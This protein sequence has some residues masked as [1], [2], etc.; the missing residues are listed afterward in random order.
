MFIYKGKTIK[1]IGLFGYGKSNKGIYEFFNT[2][3]ED[4]RFILRSDHQKDTEGAKFEKVLFGDV[5]L[6]RINEDILFL[7]PSV[8]RDKKELAFA[9]KRGVILSSDADFFLSLTKS[10]VYA[11]TGSDGKSTTTKLSAAMLSESYARAVACGNIGEAMTPH[12]SDGDNCAYVT[13]LSSFQLTYMKPKSQRALITNITKNHLNWHSSFDEYINAKRNVFEN[14]RERII[15][16]DCEI[17]RSFAKDYRIFS[18]FS[19]RL[20]EVELKKAV[21]AELYV[22]LNDGYITVSGEKML[23][24]SDIRVKG[25]HNVENFMAAI[26]MSYGLADKQLILNTAKEFTGLRHRCEFVGERDGIKY[27]D[28][29]IDSSPKRTSATLKTFDERVIVILGGRSKGLEFSDLIP[30]LKQKAKAVVLMGECAEEIANTLSRDP[31]FTT[32]IP[33]TIRACL[34]DALEYAASIARHGDSVL[35]S[36]AATSYDEFKN[37]EERGDAFCN[38]IH[39]L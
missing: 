33:Y 22:T 2:L 3:P 14:A 21:E 10:D 26:A 12:L 23:K 6:K 16:F 8:R 7:S 34:S 17:S 29:S 20:S 19:H 30:T 18:V 32:D 15:N 13:E 27:Y 28:S 9:E 24:I 36:P 4:F 31:T 35:L 5:A 1:S 39:G 11:I 38:L 25:T 37:F